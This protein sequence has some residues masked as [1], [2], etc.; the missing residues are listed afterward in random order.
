MKRTRLALA[1]LVTDRASLLAAVA[2]VAFFLLVVGIVAFAASLLPFGSGPSLAIPLV[3]FFGLP[4]GA[5]VFETLKSVRRSRLSDRAI[6]IG[7]DAAGALVTFIADTALRAAAPPPK[8]IWVSHGFD[9]SVVPHARAYDL[10]VGLSILDVLTTNEFGALVSLTLA[11]SFGDDPLTARAYRRLQGWVDVA[12]ARPTGIS[13]GAGVAKAI[14]LGSMVLLQG[15]AVVAAREK[16]ARSEAGRLWGAATLDGA[17]LRPAMYASY[18]TDVFWP[19][20]LKRHAAN[21][22]PPDAMSQHRAMCRSALPA[23][24]APRRMNRAAAELEVHVVDAAHVTRE[25]W[26][27]ASETLA[28]AIQA[29]LTRAFDLVWRVGM[30]PGWAEMRTAIA[31][32]AAELAAIERAAATAP[33]TDRQDLRRLELIEERD[34][35]HVAL[36]LYRDWLERHPSDGAATFRTGYA[37]LAEHAPDAL[38]L[39]ERAMDLDPRYRTECC[40]LIAEELRAQGRESEAQSYRERQSQ[41]LADLEAALKA[42]AG[43]KANAALI[44]PG[45]SDR[46]I[47]TITDHVRT[48]KMITRATLV[49]RDVKEYPSIPCL[50]L[51]I[52][53]DSW[54]SL[55]H[56]ER[57][58][59]TLAK[60]ADV[61]LPVQIIPKRASRKTSEPP[62]IEIYRAPRPTRAQRLARWG[63]RGQVVLIF[64][65]LFLVLRASFDNRNCF[66]DC[67][68]KPEAFYYLVPLI[69]AINVFL[70]TGSPDTAPRRAAA[71]LASLMVVTMMVLSGWWLVFTPLPFIALAR[72]PTT[73]RSVIWTIALSAPAFFLGVLVA[74]S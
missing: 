27:P 29:P 69:V 32:S 70:L 10:L 26:T 19:A 60:A 64:I 12:L 68:L 51:G 24:E 47:E 62:A 31:K 4:Y 17:M 36:P 52:G 59:T 25:S 28:P 58:D 11:R 34:G 48:F 63:R 57:I 55:M 6:C 35:P 9:L 71:F 8:R 65:A 49:R 16:H 67:W 39:L 53:F 73:R 21:I 45:L 30:M 15:E 2:F 61:P 38:A 41:A 7:P 43:P 46:E 66:P 14:A 42:R 50:V 22:E 33:L 5:I 18:A 54:W 13:V 3:I 74:Q 1:I 37:A 44:A 72:V 40:G 23:D 56:S 20:L